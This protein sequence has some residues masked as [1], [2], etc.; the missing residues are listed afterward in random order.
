MNSQGRDTNTVL[1]NLSN[2][3]TVVS[4]EPY[5]ERKQQRYGLP[6]L[7]SVPNTTSPG[8]RGIRP[9]HRTTLS[10]SSGGQDS[11]Y[12]STMRDS[13]NGKPD[14]RPVKQFKKCPSLHTSQ[15]DVGVNSQLHTNTTNNDCFKTYTGQAMAAHVDRARWMNQMAGDDM[16]NCTRHDGSNN[17]D[18]LTTY[19]QDHHKMEQTPSKPDKFNGRWRTSIYKVCNGNLQVNDARK[20]SS[21]SGNKILHETRKKS[22][23]KSILSHQVM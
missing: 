5:N 1:T 10:L 3:L 12:T 14:L 22:A 2:Y 20:F 7:R 18:F 13:F 11:K 23:Q 4:D 17:I 8:R 19:S 21:L 9:L 6:A 15:F 16:V